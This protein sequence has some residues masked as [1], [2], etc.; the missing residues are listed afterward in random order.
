M[1]GK[2]KPMTPSMSKIIDVMFLGGY[3]ESNNWFVEVINT[4]AA[5][6]DEGVIASD[7]RL[8]VRCIEEIVLVEC[9]LQQLTPDDAGHLLSDWRD[10]FNVQYA[11]PAL[12]GFNEYAFVSEQ[13]VREYCRY[14]N[15]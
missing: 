14:S 1:S 13:F 5:T 4:L 9:Q 3:E 15:H 7:E 11:Q 12:E 10:W 8:I 6:A 2:A